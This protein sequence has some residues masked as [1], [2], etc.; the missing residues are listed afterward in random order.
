MVVCQF[1]TTALRSEQAVFVCNVMFHFAQLFTEC[2]AAFTRGTQGIEYR[3]HLMVN[4]Y[5]NRGKA[6]A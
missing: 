4:A 3:L 2:G 5:A 1:S 6:L